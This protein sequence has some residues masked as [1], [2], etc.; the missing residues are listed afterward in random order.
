MARPVDEPRPVP[1]VRDAR[2]ATGVDCLAG[3]RPAG[4]RLVAAAWASLEHG[5]TGAGTPRP[6]RPP[7]RCRDPDRARDVRAVAAQRPADVDDDGLARPRSPGRPARGAATRCWGPRRRSRTRPFVALGDEAVADLARDV[8][9]GPPDER[10]RAPPRP[11]PGPRRA[12]AARSSATSSASLRIRSARSTADVSE[13]RALGQHALETRGRTPRASRRTR[14]RRRSPSAPSH[15]RR[16]RRPRPAPSGPRSPPRSRPPAR[17]LAAAGAG[18]GGRRLEAW[19]D[20]RQ[21]AP[22]SGRHHAAG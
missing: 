16:E 18:A 2:R 6:G 12:A 13:N 7:G 10:A 5:R 19:R 21:P 4:R 3:R 9:L 20:E 11:R 14:R 1:G 22:L 17:P 15:R 8:R